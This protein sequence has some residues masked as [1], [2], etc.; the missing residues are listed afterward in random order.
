MDIA[1][2]S[3]EIKRILRRD[4]RAFSAVVTGCAVAGVLI[5]SRVLLSWPG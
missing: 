4:S 5:L 2:R 3:G 1:D